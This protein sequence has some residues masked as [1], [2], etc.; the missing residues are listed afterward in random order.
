MLSDQGC[1]CTTSLCSESGYQSEERL[2]SH[3]PANNVTPPVEE[4]VNTASRS[5]THHP[6][7]IAPGIA[8][9]ELGDSKTQSNKKEDVSRF[10][11]MLMLSNVLRVLIDMFQIYVL[12]W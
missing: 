9:N 7:V 12:L 3:P 6:P 1:V 11:F 10:I 5:D 8:L 2:F 4:D